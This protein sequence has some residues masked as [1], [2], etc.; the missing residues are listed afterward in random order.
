MIIKVHLCQLKSGSSFIWS[1]LYFGV[2][3]IKLTAT[4]IFIFIHKSTFLLNG[5]RRLAWDFCFDLYLASTTISI[6]LLPLI[7]V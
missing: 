2:F 7:K 5:I 1:V 6:F 3:L 4:F